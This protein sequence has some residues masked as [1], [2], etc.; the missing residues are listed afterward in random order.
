MLKIT[1]IKFIKYLLVSVDVIIEDR[2]DDSKYKSI[3]ISRNKIVKILIKSRSR[4]L[5]RFK[6]V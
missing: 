6:K 5:F 2:L 1:F 4:N 3:K